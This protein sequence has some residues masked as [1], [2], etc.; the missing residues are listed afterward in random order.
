MPQDTSNPQ[1]FDREIINKAQHITILIPTY[2]RPDYIARNLNY[3][4]QCFPLPALRVLILDS[5][6]NL[7]EEVARIASRFPVE[8]YRFAP[9]TLF[10]EKLLAGFRLVTTP[11]VAILADDDLLVPEGLYTSIDFLLTHPD[12]SIASGAYASLAIHEQSNLKCKPT[13]TQM[14]SLEGENP[15]TRLLNFYT[16]YGPLYYAVHRTSLMQKIYEEA[17]QYSL[18]AN[19]DHFQ[20]HEELMIDSLQVILGKY[21]KLPVYYYIREVGQSLASNRDKLSPIHF[22]LSPY[23]HPEYKRFRDIMKHYLREALREDNS[24]QEL[25]EILDILYG[26]YINSALTPD[27]LLEQYRNN[28]PFKEYFKVHKMRDLPYYFAKYRKKLQHSIKVNRNL[29]EA[30]KIQQLTAIKFLKGYLQA[31]NCIK[32]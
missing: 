4:S 16:H 17:T 5:S 7:S 15:L 20:C 6:P 31:D 14:R 24:D 23:F 27:R 2:D 21:K 25:E 3:L 28:T 9:T 8:Y 26:T 18:Q 29:A 12:Y 10:A 32:G 1:R 19:P 13:Y 11:L 22:L 30:D